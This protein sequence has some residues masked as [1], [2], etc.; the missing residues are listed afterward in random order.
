VSAY[1]TPGGPV[2]HDPMSLPVDDNVNNYTFC[3][4]LKGSQWFLQKGKMIAYYGTIDFNGIGHGRLDRLVRTSFHSP[5]HASDWVVAEVDEEWTTPVD[6]RMEALGGIVL[7]RSLWEVEDTQD[8]RDIASIKA[9]IVQLKTEHAEAKAERKAKLQARIDTL[10]AKLQEKLD[11]AKSRLEAIR[12]E[13][14]AKVEALKEKVAQSK[15]DI[16]VKKEQRMA[17][18]KKHYNEWLDRQE[19][20]AS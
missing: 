2:I 15:Q 16:K 14:D 9:D 5:L 8:E 4:E 11:K 12:H 7:R 3:V 20:R 6:T 10:N 1:G 19:R 13:A 18:V 17:T